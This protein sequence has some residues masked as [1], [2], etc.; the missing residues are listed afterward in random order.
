MVQLINYMSIQPNFQ[1]RRVRIDDVD[2]SI[3]FVVTHALLGV[4][5]RTAGKHVARARVSRVVMRAADKEQRLTRTA[6]DDRT[7]L[8][9]VGQARR[10]IERD[11][12]EHRHWRVTGGDQ[13]W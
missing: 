13:H 6:R 10:Q 2:Q 1:S 7:V 3:P 12:D 11:I 8:R 4:P 5:W 9:H